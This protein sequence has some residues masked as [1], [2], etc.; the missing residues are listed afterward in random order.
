MK[1]MILKGGKTTCIEALDLILPGLG[2]IVNILSAM[3]D[4]DAVKELVQEMLE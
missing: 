2:A 1:Y 4:S 3:K